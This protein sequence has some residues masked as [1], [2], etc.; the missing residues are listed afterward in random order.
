MVGAV[1]TG[2]A[3]R[4]MGRTKALIELDGVPMAQGVVAEYR[5]ADGIRPVGP[6]S[7]RRAQTLGE[8]HG[9]DSRDTAEDEQETPD[10]IVARRRQ[11]PAQAQARTA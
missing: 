7:D 6:A 1:L 2:G 3:S 4:R 9:A 8:R 5:E 10:E 11:P